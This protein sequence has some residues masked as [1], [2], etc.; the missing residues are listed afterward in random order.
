[1]Q[2]TSVEATVE[3]KRQKKQEITQSKAKSKAERGKYWRQ[4]LPLS[5]KD[6]KIKVEYFT[7][8]LV[9]SRLATALFFSR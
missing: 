8:G 4:A 3:G 7:M 5:I 2:K 6:R 9:D 1:M